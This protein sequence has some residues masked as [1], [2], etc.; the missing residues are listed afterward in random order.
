MAAYSVPQL[1]AAMLCLVF[2]H[3]KHSHEERKRDVAYWKWMRLFVSLGASRAHLDGGRNL[4]CSGRII[5][6]TSFW[7]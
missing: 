3:I 5:T 6:R 4:N 1:P 7:C 2:M